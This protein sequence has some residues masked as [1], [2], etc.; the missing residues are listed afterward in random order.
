MNKEAT[1]EHVIQL[2][3]VSAY[4]CLRAQ[5]L[6]ARSNNDWK[7]LAYVSRVWS[8]MGVLTQSKMAVDR[9]RAL[10][11]DQVSTKV[12]LKEAAQEDSPLHTLFDWCSSPWDRYSVAEFLLS[13]YVSE[14]D[15]GEYAKSLERL[16]RRKKKKKNTRR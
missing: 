5:E 6:R 8:V 10:T 3:H 13:I 9:L 11:F 2:E 14:D 4:S 12:L 1:I 15:A 16:E 7:A